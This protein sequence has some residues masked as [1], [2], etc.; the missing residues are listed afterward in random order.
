MWGRSLL[1]ELRLLFSQQLGHFLFSATLKIGL[2]F[3]NEKNI[4]THKPNVPAT[5]NLID[6]PG[7]FLIMCPLQ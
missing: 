7:A 4:K 6:D 1:P 2:N 3:S 5:C